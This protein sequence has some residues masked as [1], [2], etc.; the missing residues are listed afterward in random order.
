MSPISASGSE[1]NDYDFKGE[2]WP[3]ETNNGNN[4][5][6]KY[7]DRIRP[8]LNQNPTDP[9]IYDTVVKLFNVTREYKPLMTRN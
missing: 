9:V 8:Y 3:N 6:K 5:M 4:V 7:I 1:C 2:I